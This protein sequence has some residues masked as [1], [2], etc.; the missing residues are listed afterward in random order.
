MWDLYSIDICCLVAN[1][2][3]N[4]YFEVLLSKFM[5]IV[6]V[7]FKLYQYVDFIFI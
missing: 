7:A 2:E 6:K 5:T 4:I 1:K 3:I